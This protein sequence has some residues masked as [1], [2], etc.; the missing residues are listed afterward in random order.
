MLWIR[1]DVARL[2]VPWSEISPKKLNHLYYPKDITTDSHR[3]IRYRLGI[4]IDKTERQYHSQE[5]LSIS[6]T[7]CDNIISTIDKTQA[8]RAQIPDL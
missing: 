4:T 3:A 1:N 2:V 7:I 5:M 8:V 6:I